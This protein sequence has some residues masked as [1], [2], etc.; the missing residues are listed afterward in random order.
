[1]R[2]MRRKGQWASNTKPGKMSAE[3]IV[4][5]AVSSCREKSLSCSTGLRPVQFGVPPNCPSG[6]PLAITSSQIQIRPN[7][8]AFMPNASRKAIGHPALSGLI[9]LK[10]Y[11]KEAGWDSGPKT[12]PRTTAKIRDYAVHKQWRVGDSAPRCPR[13]VQRRNVR[14]DLD[15]KPRHTHFS[16]TQKRATWQISVNQGESRPTFFSEPRPPKL[17]PQNDPQKFAP[18]RVNPCPSVVHSL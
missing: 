13:R 17:E 8:L 6:E 12:A 7:S 9:R 3:A 11:A 15:R 16:P 14:H 10:K 4:A 2:T 1:M 18:I 5:G